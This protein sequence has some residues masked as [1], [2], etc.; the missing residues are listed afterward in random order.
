M[1]SLCFGRVVWMNT[2]DS[3]GRNPKG[4]PFIVITS[5]DII[6]AGGPVRAIAV[7]TRLDQVPGDQMVLLPYGKGNR[8]GFTKPCAAYCRWV[9]NVEPAKI[10]SF[11]GVLSARLLADIIAKMNI[12]DK[13][14]VPDE[15]STSSEEG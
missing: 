8:L 4:R 15:D 13:S 9:E 11:G 6:E 1:S 5:N 7:T 10:E 2:L 12:T 14:K 3:Q